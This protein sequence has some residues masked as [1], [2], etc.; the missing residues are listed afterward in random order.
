MIPNVKVLSTIV[1]VSDGNLYYSEGAR[2][3]AF[4]SNDNGSLYAFMD[5]DAEYDEQVF[6]RDLKAVSAKAVLNAFRAKM[7]EQQT[8]FVYLW[9]IIHDEEPN[10]TVIRRNVYDYLAKAISNAIKIHN[11]ESGDRVMA[12]LPNS[13]DVK[14]LEAIRDAY[15]IFGS[16]NV[17]FRFPCVSDES[18]LFT[19]R[20]NVLGGRLLGLCMP[21]QLRGMIEWH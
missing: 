15:G 12:Y 13:R 16:A 5:D 6:Q 4:I 20:A 14:V 17:T 18:K 3:I 9:D 21:F 19:M 8:R 1:K 11:T 2:T 7:K 10:Q